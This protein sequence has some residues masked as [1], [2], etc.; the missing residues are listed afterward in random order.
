M[1]RQMV[2]LQQR[3]WPDLPVL[4]QP[5]APW[6]VALLLPALATDHGAQ[7]WLG[8]F[9]RCAAWGWMEGAR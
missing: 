2:A 1:W 7:A 9:E 6:C 5:D 4:E 3:V 8:D